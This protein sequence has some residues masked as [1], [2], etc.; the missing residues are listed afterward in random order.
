MFIFT[1]RMIKIPPSASP[2]GAGVRFG[3]IKRAVLEEARSRLYYNSSHGDPLYNRSSKLFMNNHR[4]S[5][6]V[7]YIY[8][9]SESFWL[10]INTKKNIKVTNIL[11]S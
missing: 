2:S 1:G 6:N 4:A 7:E 8:P 11:I 10:K 9:C 3:I 5:T